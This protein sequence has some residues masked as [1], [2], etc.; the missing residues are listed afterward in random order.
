MTVQ[1]TELKEIGT[2]QVDSGLIW[3]GDPGYVFDGPRPTDIGRSWQEFCDRYQARE[4]ETPGAVQYN[5]DSGHPGLGVAVSTGI[6]DG[7]YP[8]YAE[9]EDGLVVRVVIQF[10]GEPAPG[11]EAEVMKPIDCDAFTFDLDYDLDLEFS[12]PP[13]VVVRGKDATGKD[14]GLAFETEAGLRLMA[15]LAKAIAKLV[16]ICVP[17]SR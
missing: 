4:K 3:I 17:Q 14:F 8:V 5:S 1:A 6:G 15:G 7:F 13:T 11:Q 9:I 10:F 16:S 2:V 12:P